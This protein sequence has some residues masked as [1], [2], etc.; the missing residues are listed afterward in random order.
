MKVW[1][2]NETSFKP[3]G[4][5]NFFKN[6]CFLFRFAIFNICPK[7]STFGLPNNIHKMWTP[8]KTTIRLTFLKMPPDTLIWEQQRFRLPGGH[9]SS[10]MH[11]FLQTLYMLAVMV[12]TAMLMIMVLVFTPDVHYRLTAENRPSMVDKWVKILFHVE[13]VGYAINLLWTKFFFLRFSGHNLR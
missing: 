9:S 13:R 2:E 4:I 3:T 10:A 1:Y 12:T 7:S 11:L 8:L 5:A 6:D